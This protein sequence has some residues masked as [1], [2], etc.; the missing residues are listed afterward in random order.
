MSISPKGALTT[1]W[2]ND[3]AQAWFC[4]L[5]GGLRSL[6]GVS[7]TISESPPQHEWLQ[8]PQPGSSC[9][10]C[11]QLYWRVPSPSN[12]L[13]LIKP[14]GGTRES[15]DFLS[16]LCLYM[17]WLCV[18]TPGKNVWDP[19]TGTQT[20]NT[21]VASRKAYLFTCLFSVLPGVSMQSRFLKLQ[22]ATGE[23]KKS[24]A[25]ITV[26]SSGRSQVWPLCI[27]FT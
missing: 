19:T 3:S 13:L 24:W 25:S 18:L 12:C 23:T 4:G 14:C 7:V 17:V 21:A 10:P 1:D 8:K 5:E 22:S 16:F 11:R 6:T 2:R 9:T 27:F 15:R 26:M 20:L